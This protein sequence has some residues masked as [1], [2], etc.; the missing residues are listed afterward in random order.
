MAMDDTA[1]LHRSEPKSAD[2]S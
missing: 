1:A 2:T